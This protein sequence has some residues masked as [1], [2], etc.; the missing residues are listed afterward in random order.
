ML[1]DVPSLR[2]VWRDAALY[3]PPTDTD[4]L[5]AALARLIDDAHERDRM[6]QRAIARASRFT[7]GRMVD[8]YL[9]AYARLRAPRTVAAL[10]P[11][12][13]HRE[14]VSCGS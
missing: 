5:H 1:G 7:S 12:Q 2:E 3:V 9:A 6:A 14:A 10:S 13:P 11:M 8:A 4:A